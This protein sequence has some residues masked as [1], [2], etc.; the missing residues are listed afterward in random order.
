MCMYI[1]FEQRLDCI[2]D[3]ECAK[4]FA[5][6]TQNVCFK[7]VHVVYFPNSVNSKGPFENLCGLLST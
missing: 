5:Y 6:P 7:R 3:H 4:Y 1:V 2:K